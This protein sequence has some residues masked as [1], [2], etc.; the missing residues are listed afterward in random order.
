MLSSEELDTW[1]F[2]VCEKQGLENTW[3]FFKKE[4]AKDSQQSVLN[5]VEIRRDCER[6]SDKEEQ[7]SKPVC[8][9]FSQ[10][11]VLNINEHTRRHF[12]LIQWLDVYLDLFCKVDEQIIIISL[13]STSDFYISW[14]FKPNTSDISQIS[15][16]L[17]TF[18]LW[19]LPP[20]FYTLTPYYKLTLQCYFEER[21]FFLT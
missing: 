9:W 12:L 10:K 15:Q 21:K 20:R 3:F 17:F 2:I 13:I 19:K 6:T 4:G 1:H 7:M 5:Y 18:Q 14:N 16:N 11:R 8:P